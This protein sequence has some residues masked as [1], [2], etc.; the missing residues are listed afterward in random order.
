[1]TGNPVYFVGDVRGDGTDRDVMFYRTT[2]NLLYTGEKVGAG[3]W[4]NT[5]LAQSVTALNFEYF[6]SGGQSLGSSITSD[7]RTSIKRVEITLTML[8]PFS[9]GA[10]PIQVTKTASVAIRSALSSL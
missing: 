10:S 5:E 9:A 8:R 4:T 3:N 1:M 7:N 6:N 2:G